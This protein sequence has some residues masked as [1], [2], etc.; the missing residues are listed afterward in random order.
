MRG[1]KED[2]QEEDLVMGLVKGY[3]WWPG[4]VS[5]VMGRK[6]YKV[7]FF[8]DFSYAT[9]TVKQMRLLT[10]KE[11]NSERANSLLKSALAAAYRV[12]EKKSNIMQ[13]HKRMIQEQKGNNTNKDNKSG[14][15]TEREKR[16]EARRARKERTLRREREK[17]EN[18]KKRIKKKSRGRS[19]KTPSKLKETKKSR[20]TRSGRNKSQSKNK[21]KTESSKSN[22]KSERIEIEE[23]SSQET[24]KKKRSYRLKSKKKNSQSQIE[25]NKKE[26][27][28]EE[29]EN[30]EEIKKIEEEESSK[31]KINEEESEKKLEPVE[32]E[33]EKSEPAEKEL[34]VQNKEN[35]ILES[36][37]KEDKSG[38]IKDS[39]IIENPMEIQEEEKELI[40]IS[41]E[42]RKKDKTDNKSESIKSIQR[43]KSNLF[44]NS[45]ANSEVK[46]EMTQEPKAE[47]NQQDL[48][49]EIKDIPS[50]HAKELETPQISL[51]QNDNTSFPENATPTFS[52]TLA[53]S[54]QIDPT[55][56]PSPDVRIMKDKTISKAKEDSPLMKIQPEP[57]RSHIVIHVD[58]NLQNI[59]AEIFKV[60]E[61][62]QEN[63]PVIG[64]KDSLQKWV[65]QIN[66]MGQ[67]SGIVKT[68]IGRHLSSM[69]RLCQAQVER[70]SSFD[71]VLIEIN[72]LMNFIIQRITRNFF[73]SDL[74]DWQSFLKNDDSVITTKRNESPSS[75]QRAFQAAV[76]CLADLDRDM[77]RRIS[78]RFAKRIYKSFEKGM[79]SRANSQMLGR[80]VE[81]SLA[82]T[83]S[84]EE[85]YRDKVRFLL[86]FIEKKPL[87][88]KEQVL[89]NRAG[90]CDVLA[91]QSKVK[92][93]LST[94]D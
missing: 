45:K 67:I 90:R 42:S 1:C 94:R 73:Q 80:K 15:L 32:L 14:K 71:N 11:F 77:R 21:S 60:V 38:Q 30:N 22:K 2:F 84:S 89:L 6:R 26:S 61:E 31:Q 56:E 35:N 9:L 86:D 41:V 10:S 69:R 88:F 12:K 66:Q 3:P 54:N 13:E 49:V 29:N 46:N 64:L 23:D 18:K 63:R 20:N 52:N 57:D 43:N 33:N 76:W 27:Q 17:E 28:N 47:N 81:D 55:N 70:Q 51:A 92:D 87:Y 79:L 62:L 75:F 82:T 83:C 25:S 8:G 59:E 85:D 44:E 37:I 5:E 16:L 50:Q 78:V 72:E 34:E 7:T 65:G 68:K 4:F 48:T 24:P 39:K 19:K 53:P 58:K 93:V 36:Q 91:M 74:P 40:K